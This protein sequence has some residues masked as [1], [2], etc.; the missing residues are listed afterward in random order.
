MAKIAWNNL[1]NECKLFTSKIQKAYWI[2]HAIIIYKIL[3]NKG[4]KEWESDRCQKKKNMN[5]LQLIHPKNIKNY[6]K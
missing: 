5:I 2:E 4:S 3:N 6:L 1:L